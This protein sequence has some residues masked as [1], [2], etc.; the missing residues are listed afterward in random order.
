[1]KRGRPLRAAGTA[2]LP[3][4]RLRPVL[5]VRG[6]RP[7]RT[8]GALVREKP[9]RRAALRAA[10]DGGGERVETAAHARRAGQVEAAQLGGA[11]VAVAGEGQLAQQ[12]QGRAQAAQLM[13]KIED[14]RAAADVPLLMQAHDHL[15]VET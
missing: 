9:R 4:P 7:P 2:A 1:M 10:A 8:L 13:R 15:A 5:A 6:S 3:G 14:A 12:A 11:L